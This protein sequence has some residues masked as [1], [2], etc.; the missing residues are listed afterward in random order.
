MHANAASVI[1]APTE[2]NINVVSLSTSASSAVDLG[3]SLGYTWLHFI[4]D[5]D[6]YI[7]FGDSSSVTDPDETATSGGGRTWY[8]P[9]GTIFSVQYNLRSRYMK[10]KGA[11]SGTLR[12]YKTGT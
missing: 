12:W 4:A 1:K 7:T 10:H 9:S 5:Q 8:V 3:D 11:A 2:G 6:F